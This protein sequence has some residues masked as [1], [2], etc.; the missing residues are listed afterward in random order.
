MHVLARLYRINIVLWG[1]LVWWSCARARLI[2]PT[3][4]PAQ[5][6]TATLERLG[7]TYVKLGQGLSLHSELLSDDTLSA[8]QKLQGRVAPFPGAVAKTEIEKSLGHPL[9][10]VFSKFESEPFAV[11]S[12][13]QVH[14][15]ALRDGRKVII[16]VRRPGIRRHIDEDVRILR[17][18]VKSVMVVIPRF[19]RFCPLELIDELLRNLYKEIAFRQEA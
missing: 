18:F 14:R 5:R 2:R 8:L 10:E 15:A 9:P 1:Y 4:A 17:W 12:I 13:A 7:T 11:G 6:F 3:I 16:K 19:R